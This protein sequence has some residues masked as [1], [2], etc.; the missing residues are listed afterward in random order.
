VQPNAATLGRQRSCH[1]GVPGDEPFLCARR[2]TRRLC[3]GVGRGHV[4]GFNPF[5]PPVFK[6]RLK[7]SCCN[8][9]SSEGW[10]VYYAV[11]GKTSKVYMLFLHHK[12]AF[13]NPSKEFLQQKIQRAFE[14]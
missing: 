2:F 7:D 11:S 1:R 9:S 12:K 6:T 4:A 8:M 3:C 10:R 14:G 5:I 13:E